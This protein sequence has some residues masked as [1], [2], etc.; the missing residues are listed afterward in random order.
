MLAVGMLVDVRRDMRGEDGKWGE[1]L[2]SPMRRRRERM[3][4]RI[5]ALVL[6][7]VDLVECFCL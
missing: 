1:W 6:G 4:S 5:M 2:T 3:S 7:V